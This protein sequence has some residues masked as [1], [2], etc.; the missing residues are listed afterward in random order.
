MKANDK[1]EIDCTINMVHRLANRA[2][3]QWENMQGNE[4]LETLLETVT[5]LKT[6]VDSLS[7][8]IECMPWWD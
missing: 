6:H 3:K 2:S 4:D 7:D 1:A 8:T 5:E